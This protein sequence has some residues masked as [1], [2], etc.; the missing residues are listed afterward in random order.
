[1]QIACG[2]NGFSPRYA[3]I[4]PVACG[5]A[6]RMIYSRY[7]DVGERELGI[8]LRAEQL[9][10]SNGRTVPSAVRKRRGVCGIFGY[11]AR[12]GKSRL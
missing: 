10:R 5:F 1:M 6:A 4:T 7:E 9:G 3:L 2:R 8:S 11:F 12:E